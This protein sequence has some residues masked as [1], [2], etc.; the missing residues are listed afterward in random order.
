MLNN[1]A[2][3][4]T[5]SVSDP[6]GGVQQVSFFVFYNG[7]W[8]PAGTDTDGSDGWSVTW[9]ATGV[10]DQRVRVRAIAGDLAGNG[11]TSRVVGKV[12]LD[13]TS[14][15]VAGVTFSSKNARVGK[16]VKITL[17]LKDNLSGV[18]SAD[19]Y[20]DPNTDGSRSLPFQLI[21]SLPPG[22]GTVTWNTGGF[23]P[24]VHDVVVFLQDRA[25]NSGGWPAL[26]SPPVKYNLLPG[27]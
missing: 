9:D 16:L 17:A 24:G 12:M 4:L 8:R 15:T 2:V 18:R 7:K 27:P 19:V 25:G 22:G 14:P 3:Q 13:R 26:E 23:A 21:G 1:D 5:A 6:C 20:I 11:V 10:K